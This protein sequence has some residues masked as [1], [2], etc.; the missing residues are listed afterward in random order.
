MAAVYLTLL[1]H[2]ICEGE[3]EGRFIGQ[4]EA[5]LT[6]QGKQELKAMA[7]AGGYP[8]AD[9]VFCSPLL[10]CK[11]TAA[12]LY[13]QLN[14]IELPDFREYFFGEYEN[15]T[16]AELQK[17]ELFHSWISGAPG[18]T[19]P[20]AESLTDF[21][22]RLTNTFALLI[23]G[24]LKTKTPH[25]VLITHGGV[26][27]ALMHRFAL[28]EAQMHEWACMP[29]TGYTLRADLRLWMQGQKCE[30]VSIAPERGAS[31]A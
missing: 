22:A 2:G 7:L 17:H 4:T 19:P 1:R 24:L 10:R 31:I 25:S 14:S 15:K 30:A 26:I 13:P 8:A 11:E 21:S 28:P 9:A 6:A 20:F 23:Q 27:M 5:P 18:V 16:P 3:S 12:I 29:G